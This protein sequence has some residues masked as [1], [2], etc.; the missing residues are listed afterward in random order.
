M[1]QSLPIPGPTE[2]AAAIVD[3]KADRIVGAEILA[4]SKADRV[5]MIN[6]NKKNDQNKYDRM[7]SAHSSGD[8][9]SSR[10]TRLSQ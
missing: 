1:Q 5:K 6:K 8:M 7:V 9:P 3:S 10:R 4:E 2:S